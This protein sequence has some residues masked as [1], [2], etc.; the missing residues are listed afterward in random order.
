MTPIEMKEYRLK[1]G[2]TQLEMAHRMGL[3][4]RAYQDMEAS[5]NGLRRVHVLTLQA[6]S[7]EMALERQDLNAALPAMRENVLRFAEL[8]RAGKAPA[9]RIPADLDEYLD[10]LRRLLADVEVDIFGKVHD[11]GFRWKVEA[12]DAGKRLI[13]GDWPKGQRIPPSEAAAMVRG[14]IETHTSERV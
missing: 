13:V 2:L 6:V 7:L 14:W 4:S 8:M 11:Y 10:E 5:P 9:A 1:L 3:S 12:H